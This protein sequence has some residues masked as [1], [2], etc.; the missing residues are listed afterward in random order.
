MLQKT[1]VSTAS[2]FFS[3]ADRILCI[4]HKNPDGDAIGSI[5]GMG[6]LLEKAYPN[7]QIS[8]H[9]VDPAPDTMHFL[10][11]VHS[12]QREPKLKEGDVIV[13]LD[14][15]AP[16]QTAMDKNIPELFDGT[17]NSIC[18]DHH[19]GNPNFGTVNFILPDAASTCEIVVQLA[20]DLSWEMDSDIAT[21][22]L[23]GVYTDTGGLLHSNTTSKVYR[24][25]ARLLRVGA[26]QQQIVT[27]VF[28]T[29][30]L[31][32]LKLWGRVLEKINLTSE[33]GAISAV[34]KGDFRATGAHHS[35][36][37]GAIDYINAVPGMKFSLLLSERGDIVKGSLRTL[38]DDIDVAKMAGKFQGGGHRK[39]AGFS[40]PGSLQPEV[41][42]KVVDSNNP[43]VPK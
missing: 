25:V 34:T 33:G 35:E 24:T 15:A 8:M 14:C 42:W 23:T 19:Q 36:L 16:G 28:R 2:K 38:R 1:D 20:D 31:S 29:A 18:I 41:R 9:C 10:P 11:R 6:L 26:R 21:C 12:I 13:F 43:S 32:T 17:H 5:L 3:S 4:C 30:K 40:L 22:L 39:A 7:K 37:T 27:H